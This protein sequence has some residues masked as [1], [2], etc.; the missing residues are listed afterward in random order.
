MK[1]RVALIVA[2]GV[3]PP[4]LAQDHEWTAG[5]SFRARGESFSAAPFG[6]VG[7]VEDDYVLWRGLVN[8]R[9]RPAEVVEAFVEVGFHEESGRAAGPAPTD[10]NRFDLHQAWLEIRPAPDT[11]L[12]LGRQEFLLGSGRLV[13][14]RDGPNIR[15]AFDGGVLAISRGSVNLRAFALKTVD[16]RRP[17]FDD[18]FFEGDTL[19]GIYATVGAD[20]NRIDIYYLALERNE[21]AY[22]GF[23]G[24]E[25]RHSL[26]IRWAGKSRAFDYDIEA[27]GQF[28]Q[29]GRSRIRAWTVA[30][31]VGW[32]L[33]DTPL[34][35]RLELKSN[36]TS[37]DANPADGTLHT[38]NPLFPNF[39][40][41]NDA[42]LLSPQNHIDLH[43]NITFSLSPHVSI[44][45]GASWFWKARRED[46]IYRAP[47]LPFGGPTTARF[48][49]RELTTSIDWQPAPDTAV[50]L[51][52]V[53]LQPGSALRQTGGQSASF[54]MLAIEQH[55]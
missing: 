16:I 36:I 28:G 37:G 34:Q 20:D 31:S 10:V 9:V 39:S 41:F 46:S 1:C 52:F 12:R 17:G 43:P 7:P 35:P 26:G 32:Q 48:V 42:A 45:A 6:T 14:L 51:S 22:R 15:R 11:S 24:P 49:A 8:V 3:A 21:A 27:V 19:A 30:S 50:R 53:H 40:Y 54:G 2:L 5:G 18:P 23:R 38:F 33:N 47:G 29:A 13:S 4:A 44:S 25:E 55:F